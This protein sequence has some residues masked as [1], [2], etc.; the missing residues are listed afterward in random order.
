MG[1]RWDKIE[2]G[3]IWDAPEKKPDKKST[4]ENKK[5]QESS[6]QLILPDIGMQNPGSVNNMQPSGNTSWLSQISF[7]P[8]L[9]LLLLI[10][11]IVILGCISFACV[12]FFTSPAGNVV[13]VVATGVA[14]IWIMKRGGGIL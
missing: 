5:K 2:K 14:F 4:S 9:M 3:D 13:A 7:M 12:K 1:G 11:V 8:V 6:S 10:P